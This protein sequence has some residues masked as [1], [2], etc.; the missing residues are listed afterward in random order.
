M[1]DRSLIELTATD[2]VALVGA[3]KVASAELIA[4]AATHISATEP[5]IGAWEVLDVQRAVTDASRWRADRRRSSQGILEGVVVGVKDVLAVRGF[6]T[7]AGFRPFHDRLA[8]SDSVVI[9]H[10]APPVGRGYRP[11]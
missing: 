11:G 7:V 2:V 5:A 6:A 10:R 3:R 8:T 1:G 4:A 9:A